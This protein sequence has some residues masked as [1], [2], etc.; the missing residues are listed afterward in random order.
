MIFIRRNIISRLRS[1]RCSGFRRLFEFSDGSAQ[2][3][4]SPVP[5]AAG[6]APFSV[7][8]ASV[9]AER[10]PGSIGIASAGAAMVSERMENAISVT[11]PYAPTDMESA[12]AGILCLS[13]TVI[14]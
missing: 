6:P 3:C 10:A 8:P 7:E 1:S 4:D 12:L 13:I 14:M 11:L 9:I 2:V 5:A